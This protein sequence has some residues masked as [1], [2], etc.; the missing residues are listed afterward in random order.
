MQRIGIVI[1]ASSDD[2]QFMEPL[3]RQLYLF[4]RDVVV[5]FGTHFW[6]MKHPEDTRK[7]EVFFSTYFPNQKYIYYSVSGEARNI[8][9]HSCLVSN[10]DMYWEACARWTGY[11]QINKNHCTHVIFLDGDEIIN[12]TTFKS[13]MR[14]FPYE[15]YVAIK[16]ANYWYWRE[17]ILRAKDIIEDSV[18]MLSTDIINPELVYN[19]GARTHMYD[20]ACGLK[21]RQM[22]GMD[23]LPMIHHYSWV[24]TKEQM[25]RKV[26]CWGHR[27]DCNNYVQLV[28]DEFTKAASADRSDF[29][30]KSKHYEFVDNIF[31]LRLIE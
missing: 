3:L 4:T 31:D 20:A 18:V 27:S 2:I 25:L 22:L 26:M 6:D 13:W 1:V 23:N 12:G 19:S 15:P 17:P 29:L 10:K 5:V 21:V 8:D 9:P 16:F 30:G 7:I 28:H 11:Q 24:R 14:K